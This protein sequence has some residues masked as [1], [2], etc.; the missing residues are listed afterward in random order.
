MDPEEVFK[1]VGFNATRSKLTN[2]EVEKKYY[3]DASFDS[4]ADEEIEEE[5]PNELVDAGAGSSTELAV[6]LRGKG[7]GTKAKQTIPNDDDLLY[8]PEADDDDETWLR[9]R[10]Q[11]IYLTAH[12]S[13]SHIL[14]SLR[15]QPI[16]QRNPYN[17]FP[18]QMQISRVRAA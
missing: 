9:N 3:D 2:T 13:L 6:S 15:T 7:K 4:D 1:Q 11:G 8:D 5:N 18:H 14:T 10:I 16:A 17:H 12:S